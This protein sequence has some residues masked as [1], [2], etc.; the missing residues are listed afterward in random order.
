LLTFVD[1]LVESVLGYRP[2]DL[3]GRRFF[4]DWVAPEER[5]RIRE[6]TFGVL[7]T[8]IP[9]LLDE[10][11]VLAHDGRVLWV[12]STVLP[13][14]RSDGAIDSLRGSII[15]IT[16]RK[17]AELE[18]EK[19]REHLEDLVEK[20][21]AALEAAQ[22]QAEAASQAK[23]TFLAN[24]SHEIRTPLN[25]VV[26][27][28]HLL[29]RELT[30]PSQVEKIRKMIISAKHLLGIIN[31]VLDLAKIEADR[32]TL[33]S[34]PLNI[35]SLVDHACSNILDRVSEKNLQLHQE[36]D[37]LLAEIT[38]L[39][40]P[41]RLN[42]IL[43]NFLSNAVKFT[44]H[45][46]IT[47]RAHLLSRQGD[48][49]SVRFEVQDTGPGLSTEL[50]DRLF[51]PFEQGE[52]RISRKYGG[53]GLGLVISR[54]L[55]R[56]MGGDTGVES[57][58]GQGSTFWADVQLHKTGI[59]LAE[60]AV[61]EI[62]RQMPRKGAR[63]LLAED[64]QVNQQVA[65]ALLESADLVV[66]VAE[67]GQEAVDCVER[68]EYDLV[69][70]DM[71]MPVMDGVEAT[72]LIRAM[73]KAAGLPVLAMT[74]NAFEE[75]RKRCEEAG[76]VGFL[77]KPVDPEWLYKTLAYWLPQDG[78]TRPLRM[79]GG[80]ST[81]PQ[82][83][84]HQEE[85]GVLPAAAHAIVEHP[86][87]TLD[88][89]ESHVEGLIETLDQLLAQLDG[90]DLRATVSWKNAEAQIKAVAG[91]PTAARVSRHIDNFELQEAGGILR[92]LRSELARS[93]QE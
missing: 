65:C 77:A 49:M 20:R 75:D 32:V 31:D 24:M 86:R 11:P 93:D 83:P 74:A 8:G 72:R 10:T 1:P 35:S 16:E 91:A 9:I 89:Q 82:V 60:T 13:V 80:H 19:Y 47:I 69:L 34:A 27:F 57:V 17:A 38:V 4:F 43:I 61:P 30:E 59:R 50:M 64:N 51:M 41:L 7:A 37:P 54:R 71:Q 28:A 63:I 6:E 2:E 5:E 45:G 53:T 40:D 42:Q 73:P 78:T 56:L 88:L 87:E 14:S 90:D 92:K 67:D 58:L 84:K 3:V 81:A 15:D 76:M 33:E 12:L 25:A 26:G 66:T 29:Q 85:P 68:G 23:S 62:G 79:A 70:M 48:A 46:H 44:E 21:T 22:I 55:A 18:L 36:V 52:S 39:G